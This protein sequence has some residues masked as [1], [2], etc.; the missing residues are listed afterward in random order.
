[1]HPLR[2]RRIPCEFDGIFLTAA[3]WKDARQVWQ[4]SRVFCSWLSSCQLFQQTHR[5]SLCASSSP[6]LKSKSAFFWVALGGGLTPAV[7]Y[8]YR[9]RDASCV[10]SS[11]CSVQGDVNTVSLFSDAHREDAEA[12]M[13]G[14]LKRVHRRPYNLLSSAPFVPPQRR[15]ATL[16]FSGKPPLLFFSIN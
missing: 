16:N 6:C 13:R 9:G 10:S 7:H 8:A 11:E 15:T 12:R 3:G 2:R 1:M 5:V 4:F 14:V